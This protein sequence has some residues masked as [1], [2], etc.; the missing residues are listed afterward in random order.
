[1]KKHLNYAFWN[2]CVVM[3][4]I[5]TDGVFVD[6]SLVRFTGD[7]GQFWSLREMLSGA[8]SYQN[9]SR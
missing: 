2:D 5:T 4:S 8:R 9:L 3:V 1:M 7:V 6:P